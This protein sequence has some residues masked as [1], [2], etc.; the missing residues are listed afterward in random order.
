MTPAA[1]RNDPTAVAVGRYA[2]KGFLPAPQ[3][4]AQAPGD[5]K[6]L[7]RRGAADLSSPGNLIFVTDVTVP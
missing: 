6:I 1:R 4:G 5:S 7:P 2:A 3:P